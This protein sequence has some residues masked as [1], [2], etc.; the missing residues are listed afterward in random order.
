MKTR[1]VLLLPV[2]A[3]W[4]SAAHCS[5]EIVRIPAHLP[6]IQAGIDAASPGDTVLVDAGGKI[7]GKFITYGN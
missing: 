6:T 7:I 5:A 3:F 4:L 1:I 2:F